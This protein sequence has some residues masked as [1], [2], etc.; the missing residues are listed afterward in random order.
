[1]TVIVAGHIC[2]DII[3]QLAGISREAFERWLW[4]RAEAWEARASEGAMAAALDAYGYG[5]ERARALERMAKRTFSIL[6]ALEPAIGALVGVV[7]LDQH[8]GAVSF[9]GV[10]MVVALAAVLAVTL[11]T[12]L[13]SRKES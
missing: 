13:P 9:L 10:A 11:R 1:M 6:V 12:S 7:L 2:L 5:T 8:L 4:L 3:P